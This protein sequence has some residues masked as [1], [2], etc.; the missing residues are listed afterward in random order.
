MELVHRCLR[1]MVP[2]TLVLVLHFCGRK[3]KKEV[4][5]LGALGQRRLVG[6]D[7]ALEF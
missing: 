4:S 7:L 3:V 2:L 5:G 1:E 6:A